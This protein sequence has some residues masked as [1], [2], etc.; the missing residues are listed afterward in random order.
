MA[1]YALALAYKWSAWTT[2]WSLILNNPSSPLKAIGILVHNYVS[3]VK[4][5][6]YWHM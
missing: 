5:L 4:Q 3:F 2:G 6:T 1:P